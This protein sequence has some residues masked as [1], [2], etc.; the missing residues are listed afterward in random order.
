MHETLDNDL[1][2]A[3]PNARLGTG[4]SLGIVGGGQLARMTAMAALQLGCNVI[5]LERNPRSP[6]ATLATHSL[7]GDW[8]ELAQLRR[9]ADLADVVT[10]ENEFIDASL[11]ARLEKEGHRICPGAA[12]LAVVQDKLLQKEALLSAGLPVPRFQAVRTPADVMLAAQDMGWPL[13]LKT[14]R[15]G[16]DGKGNALVETPAGVSAAWAKLNGDQN[17]LYIEEFCPFRSELAV[18][19]ARSLNGSA[20]SYPLVQSV[21]RDHVC[22]EVLAP[23]PVPPE[24]AQ[25]ALQIAQA[26]VSAVRGVG[27][28]GVEMF[29]LGDDRVVLNELA[30]RVHNSGHYSIEACVCS[31]FENHVRAVLGWPLGSPELVSPAAAMVNLLGSGRAS[32][33]PLGLDQALCVRGAHV[34][35][36]GKLVAGPGRKM[37]HVTALGQTAEEALGIARQAARAIHFGET[38]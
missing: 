28:F 13:V 30:P 25:K 10:F 16:Y 36:Y 6:A 29:L 32:G 4:P 33:P 5:I 12:T 3:D 11:M 34:H 23:A 37:G 19:I 24:T 14:R 31:Q 7:V 17:A 18:I 26:A 27:S 22:H 1:L 15:N 8:A 20:V 35:L 38:L 21:Q 2:K 9:L